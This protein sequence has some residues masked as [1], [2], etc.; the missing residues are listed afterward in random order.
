MALPTRVHR[1]Q[2]AD[3]YESI[4]R[5]FDSVLGRFLG[6]Q[7]ATDGGERLAPYCVDVRE[8]ADHFYVEAN[9]PA[10]EKKTSTSP[11]RT[12]N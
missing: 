8:D 2:Y 1:G 5:E 9:C 7:P 12:S 3:P 10:S 11:W 6:G 4:Q